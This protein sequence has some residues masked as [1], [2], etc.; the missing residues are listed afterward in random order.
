MVTA[1]A[2][3]VDT[4]LDGKLSHILQ[5]LADMDSVLVAF[6]GGVDSTLLLKLA[7][8]ALGDRAVA[9][10][11]VS[12]SYP[13]REL[14]E[15]RELAARIGAE[16]I[17]VNTDE[18]NDPNYLSNPTNRCYFCKNELFTRLSA[19]ATERGIRQVVDGFNADDVGDWRPG[20]KAARELGVR[21]PLEE[22]RLTKA[23]IRE[24]SRRYG[25]PTW[26]KPAMACLSSRV[27]YGQFITSAKL[28]QID[29]AEQALRQLGFRVLR[30]RHHETLARIEV[31]SD[32]LPRLLDAAVRRRVL[33]RFR[34]I[35]YSYVTIDL[36]GYRQG[37]LN[38]AIAGRA[39]HPA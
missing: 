19:I 26:D 6:S 12:A 30:V 17:L 8:E 25:L 29:A 11:G 13:E 14:I 23:N 21:S 15:A 2:P 27:P 37:S 3:A 7:R 35:G 32:E 10:S 39:K 18:M 36:E 20:R 28:S 16:H 5:T 24:L 4:T 1:T 31:G 34:E 22:A 38:E 9:V 33:E